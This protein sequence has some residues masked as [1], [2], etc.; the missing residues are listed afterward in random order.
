[1]L[2][3]QATNSKVATLRSSTLE[4]TARGAASIAGLEIGQWSSLD[5]VKA[6][7]RS[8]SRFEPEESL[9]VDAGYLAWCRALER[10]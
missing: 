2:A 1:L 7:W 3:L 6:A 4:A 10:A 5:G 9:V 8:M